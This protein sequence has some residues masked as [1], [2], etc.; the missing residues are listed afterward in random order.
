MT[1]ELRKELVHE[2]RTIIVLAKEGA[3]RSV[4][5]ER[6]R[7]YWQIGRVIFDEE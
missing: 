5:T 6:V 2:I 3:I 4:D 1:M 7:M